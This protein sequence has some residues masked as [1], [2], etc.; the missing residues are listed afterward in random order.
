MSFRHAFKHN[1]GSVSGGLTPAQKAALLFDDGM[2]GIRKGGLFDRLDLT[3]MFVER[4]GTGGNPAVSGSFGLWLDKKHMGGLL[5]AQYMTN[6]GIS[7]PLLVPG[8]HLIAPADNARLVIEADG[9][10]ADGVNDCFDFV[11]NPLT[12]ATEAMIFARGYF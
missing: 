4:D 1:L 10:D 3:S 6:E 11:S 8:I 12:G 5:A 7:D 2:G 9:P